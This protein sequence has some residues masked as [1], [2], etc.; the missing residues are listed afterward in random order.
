MIH[1]CHNSGRK[2]D[3]LRFQVFYLIL[4]FLQCGISNDFYEKT[5][6]LDRNITTMILYVTVLGT[7]PLL[8]CNTHVSNTSS[9]KSMI[10]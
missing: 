8:A 3:F 2:S 7:Y 4:N 6:I 9:M 5:V 10:I 1:I